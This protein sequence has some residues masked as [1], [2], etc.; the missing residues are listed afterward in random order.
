[1]MSAS[2]GMV[3]LGCPKNL[4]DTEV[5]LGLLKKDGYVI[6]N[7]PETADIIII[8]TC[9]FIEA[10]KRESIKT[11]LEMAQ[12]KEKGRCKALI[13]SGC[14]A[15]EYG[16]ELFHIIPEIDFLTG[17][18]EL[19]KIPYIINNMVSKSLNDIKYFLNKTGFLYDHTYPRLRATLPH[20]AYIKIAE[21]CD[22]CCSYCLIPR[23][24]GKYRSR[25]P[26][27]IL[28]EALSLISEGIKEICLVAQDTTAF[29]HDKG[30][31]GSLS[32][33]LEMLGSLKDLPWIR[34]LYTNPSSVGSDVI[35]VMARYPNIVPYL[36]IPLQHTDPGILR[37]MNRPTDMKRI[38][39][40][41]CLARSIIPGIVIRTTFMVGF[42]GETEKAFESMLEYIGRIRFDRLGVFIYSREENT[43]AYSLPGQV[44]KSVKEKRYHNVMKLQAEISKEKNQALIGKV[45]EAI[46]DYPGASRKGIMI[47]RIKGQAPEID[48]ITFIKG[49]GL[50][51]G[52]IYNVRIIKAGEYDLEGIKI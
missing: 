4:V 19:M 31:R 8:N 41:I 15:Q 20:L 40:I 14:L 23:F 46:C 48:G 6:T 24:R 10:S 35:E 49:K 27:S 21:G 25:E 16:E 33:L 26:E 12:M 1:M 50:K 32:D 36:D 44:K 11:I 18:G 37:A 13:V 47:G 17:P 42:P 45:M 3:S 5:I 34:L 9:S 29:G 39:D 43:R 30:K 7:E 51:S 2:I 52:E 38:E 28:K 22:N